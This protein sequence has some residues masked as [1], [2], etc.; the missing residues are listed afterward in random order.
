MPAIWCRDDVPHPGAA[1]ALSL[2]DEQ[3]EFQL[4]DW[5]S[6][7]R[8]AGPALHQAVPDAKTIWLYRKQLKQAGAIEGLFRRFDAVLAAKGFSPWVDRSSMQP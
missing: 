6:F 5:L 7:M 1:G 4:R 8:F 2:S 3:A